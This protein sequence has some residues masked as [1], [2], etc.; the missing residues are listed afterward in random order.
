VC[1]VSQEKKGLLRVWLA[2]HAPGNCAPLFTVRAP[3]Y[4]LTTEAVALFKRPS[5]GVEMRLYVVCLGDPEGEA[6]V[7]YVGKSADPWARWNG[8]HLRNL[9]AAVKGAKRSGYASWVRLF[10]S[11]D[12]T[13]HLVCVSESRIEF[14]PIPRFP[15]TV[16]SVEYQLVSLAYD[17]F[18]EYLLN[19]E[20]VAR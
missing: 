14:P 4:Q 13:I 7:A 8:G 16:G 3:S 1:G 15:K 18:P 9:R 10:E 11:S 5:D 12:E 17:C 19:R 20:G 6:A 2:A